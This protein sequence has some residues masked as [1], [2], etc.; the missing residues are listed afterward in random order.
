MF[1]VIGL[2]N[3]GPQY[4]NTPHNVG[5][6]AVDAF[7]KE[8]NFPDFRLIKKYNTA[9][10]QSEMAG[11]K[12][13]LA[14]P[15]TFMNESGDAVKKLMAKSRLED[16]NTNL[17][18]VHDD[19]VFPLG[20]IKIVKKRG[21]NHHKGIE[22]IMSALGHRDFIRIRIGTNKELKKSLDLKDFVLSK[23]ALQDK[24]ELT[25]SLQKTTKAIE[26]IITDGIDK[27]MTKFNK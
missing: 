3:P 4:E 7:G 6:L 20:Q 18:V 17:I 12:V 21:A 24:I 5:F 15:Q 14:K 22:S 25:A 9:T 27:A 11:Q 2:G 13:I 26:T 19:V 1:I 8:N 10:S 23:F 16:T